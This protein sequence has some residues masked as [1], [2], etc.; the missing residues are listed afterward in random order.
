MDENAERLTF[1]AI[2]E[3]DID[4]LLVEELRCS[5]AFQ[6]WFLRAVIT[7]ASEGD[8]DTPDRVEVW[9]SVSH[10]ARVTE[11]RTSTPEVDFA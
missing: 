10:R 8:T 1:A 3:R 6:A 11:S 5:A 4:L 7:A 9:H 2:K